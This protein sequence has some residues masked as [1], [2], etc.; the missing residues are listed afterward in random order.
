MPR[1]FWLF[2]LS[3]AACAAPPDASA[4]PAAAA[5]AAFTPRAASQ[6]AYWVM[7]SRTG[8][9]VVEF[10]ATPLSKKSVVHQID[11]DSRNMLQNA[12]CVRVY[13]N[14]AWI[15]TAP[16][17]SGAPDE[18]LIFRLPLKSAERPLYYDK[19]EGSQFAVHAEFD[20]HGNLWVSSLGHSRM[21]SNV[22]E[23]S[24]DFFLE[25][26]DIT[27]ALTLTTGLS[28]PQGLGFDPNGNLYV[29][30]G[31]TSQIA[32]F[33]QPIQNRQP[34]YLDGV[35]NPGALAFDAHGNL[36]AASN[37]G[38]TGAIV[39]YRSGD[40]RSGDKPDVVD[41]T[42]IQAGPYGSDLGFDKAGNLYDGD[43]GNTAGIYTYPLATKKFTSHLAPS[44]YTNSTILQFG[45]VWGLAIH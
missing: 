43:C 38:S 41:S 16:G 39:E 14:L 37:E 4:P 35:G 32:V 11:G 33:A 7:F 5:P 8:Q 26:G 29:A 44:F 9:P 40:L 27:P 45:C 1:Y 20:G 18:L 2:A 34:Y 21:N 15:L 12:C 24:A 22:N 23:Y 3:L 13:H 10:A 36:F 17:G 42:G 6:D 25:G 31:K 19:L 30:N 28:G